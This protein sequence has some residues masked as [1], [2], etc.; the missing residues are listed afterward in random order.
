[1]NLEDRQVNVR[2]SAS[3]K[4]FWSRPR[5]TGQSP[6]NVS[7]D[8]KVISQE[9]RSFSILQDIPRTAPYQ[10]QRPPQRQLPPL[11]NSRSIE[12]IVCKTALQDAEN[13]DPQPLLEIE[14][15]RRENQLL[16]NQYHAVMRINTLLTQ[17]MSLQ[18]Q[19]YEDLLSDRSA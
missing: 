7:P 11:R 15:L 10:L 5:V 3:A 14:R 18:A 17:E 1:M 8:G 6:G 16:K 12:R 9:L 4:D 2:T 13:I 19:S